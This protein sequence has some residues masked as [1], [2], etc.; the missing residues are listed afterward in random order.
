MMESAKTT[1]LP[2]QPVLLTKK[3]LRIY[4]QIHCRDTSGILRRE[5]TVCGIEIE[6]WKKKKTFSMLE[7]IQIRECFKLPPP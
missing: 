2:P 5:L 7:S 3:W 4:L 6:N 1:F